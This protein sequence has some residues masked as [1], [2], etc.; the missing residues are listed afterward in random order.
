MRARA[1][2]AAVQPEVGE[3]VVH[4]GQRVQQR[5]QRVARR[6]AHGHHR[7]RCL[8]ALAAQRA[9]LGHQHADLV[10]A[11]TPQYPNPET[12]T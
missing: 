8:R 10:P 6:A 3:D 12:Q 1:P 5:V 11:A 7:A 2:Q 9:A 4:G